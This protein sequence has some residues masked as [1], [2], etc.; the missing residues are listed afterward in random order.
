MPAFNYA[1]KMAG[2]II[3]EVLDLLPGFQDALSLLEKVI[4]KTQMCEHKGQP[5]GKGRKR[6]EQVSLRR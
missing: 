4:R 1:L 5:C 3:G 6:E 2:K